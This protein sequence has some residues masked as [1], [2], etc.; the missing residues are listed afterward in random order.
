MDEVVSRDAEPAKGIAVAVTVS[1]Q[2]GDGRSIVM[3]TY[4]DR[5]AE[6][7]QFDGT[8]D[9]LGAVVDRQEAKYQLRGL[10]ANLEVHEA[11]LKQ[12]ETDY[13]KIEQNATAEWTKRGK[14]GTPQLAASE[15]AQKGNAEQNIKRYR[16]EIVKIKAEIERCEGLVQGT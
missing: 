14:K 9:K 5:D 3:Q 16:Q 1:T 2:L 13:A 15:L 11:T 8:L 12:L 7:G 10:K 4:L 6:Q